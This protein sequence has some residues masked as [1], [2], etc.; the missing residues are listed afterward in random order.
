MAKGQ[1]FKY[2]RRTGYAR[3]ASGLWHFQN[4]KV[5]RTIFEAIDQALRSRRSRVAWFWFNG[6]PAPIVK[7]DTCRSLH[8]RWS[9]WRSAYQSG[10]CSKFLGKLEEL[11]RK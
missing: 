3:D 8:Q 6:T 2:R 10:D 7:G 5:P 9:E 1:V 11:T 4:L